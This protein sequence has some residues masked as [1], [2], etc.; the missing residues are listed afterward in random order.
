MQQPSSCLLERSKTLHRVREDLEMASKMGEPMRTLQKR[1]DLFSI[2]TLGRI[3]G[4][5][6][7]YSMQ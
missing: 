5:I 2:A 7:S 1:L 3:P 4:Y 6:S